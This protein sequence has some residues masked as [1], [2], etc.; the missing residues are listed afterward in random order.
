MVEFNAL[1]PGVLY[2]QCSELC[3]ALHSGIPIVV[4][5]IPYYYFLLWLDKVRCKHMKKRTKADVFSTK[6]LCDLVARLGKVPALEIHYYI[7]VVKDN[8]EN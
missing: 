4:E 8:Y 6:F 2:G 5:V 7:W 1:R 3:G